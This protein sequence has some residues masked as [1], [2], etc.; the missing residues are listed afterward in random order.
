MND[1]RCRRYLCLM[2]RTASVWS[3]AW[4]ENSMKAFERFTRHVHVRPEFLV[5]GTLVLLALLSTST[6]RFGLTVVAASAGAP[7][8]PGAAAANKDGA[9]IRPFR[10]NVPDAD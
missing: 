6:R 10:A 7:S 4:K 5:V 9:A 8:E 3:D 1:R 2:D